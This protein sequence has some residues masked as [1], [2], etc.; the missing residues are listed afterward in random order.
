MATK[1]FDFQFDKHIASTQ[2]LLPDFGKHVMA[3]HEGELHAVGPL[4]IGTFVRYPSGIFSVTGNTRFEDKDFCATF[5]FNS[6]ELWLQFSSLLV[7]D[8]REELIKRLI[9]EWEKDTQAVVSLENDNIILVDIVAETGELQESTDEDYIPLVV[10]SVRDSTYPLV[11]TFPLPD[12]DVIMSRHEWWVQK[13]EELISLW[14]S[15]SDDLRKHIRNRRNYK[16]N[17]DMKRYNENLTLALLTYFII[18]GKPINSIV[19]FL[20][21][22]NRI[23]KTGQKAFSSFGAKQSELKQAEKEHLKTFDQH[24]LCILQWYIS[25]NIYDRSSIEDI[26][27][28][29]RDIFDKGHLFH[30]FL[31]EAIRGLKR[32]KA[33]ELLE[34]GVEE[35]IANLLKNNEGVAKVFQQHLEKYHPEYRDHPEIKYIFPHLLLYKLIVA[36]VETGYEDIVSPKA[37]ASS[38]EN[39]QTIAGWINCCSLIECNLLV[40]IGEEV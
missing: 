5:D 30:T 11:D 34:D 15:P 33:P 38:L 27:S 29:L 18:K 21:S 25:I 32:P 2:K 16:H 8:I 6:E 28:D 9:T 24:F 3:N 36:A 39:I 4:L 12:P 7:D 35:E 14:C 26:K 10:K 17:L 37:Y 1:G 22:T 19:D 13:S 23:K 40:P 31:F 20:I